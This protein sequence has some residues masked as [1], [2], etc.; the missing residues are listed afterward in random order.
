MLRRQLARLSRK[1]Q[2]LS[3]SAARTAGIVAGAAAM[4]RVAGEEGEGEAPAPAGEALANG[5]A[6][7]AAGGAKEGDLDGSD[8]LMTEDFEVEVRGWFAS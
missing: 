8:P 2:A 3:T 5:A 4:Q 1:H 6:A 7:A